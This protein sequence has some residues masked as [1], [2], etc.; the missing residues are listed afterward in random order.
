MC[1][2]GL[3]WVEGE[4][5]CLPFRVD[6]PPDPRRIAGVTAFALPL[7]NRAYIEQV[8]EHIKSV[9][10]NTLRV[11]FETWRWGDDPPSLRRLASTW[12]V[13]RALAE[14]GYLPQGPPFDSSENLANVR[15]VLDTTA[16][17][18]I[19]VELIPVFTIKGMGDLDT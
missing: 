19:W 14:K 7:H 2:E 4:G 11:G 15:R 13:G 16:R 18:G 17:A 9:G 3:E 1:P 6:V 5:A 8:C 10:Y 12:E